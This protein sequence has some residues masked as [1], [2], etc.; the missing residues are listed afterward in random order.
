MPQLVWAYESHTDLV[1]R[2]LGIDP[3]EFRRRNL[4][5]DG[6]AQATGTIMHDAAISAVLDR[7]AVRMGWDQPFDRGTE[8]LKRGRGIAIGFKASISPTTSVATVAIA[9][10]GS[11]TLYCGTVDM[12]QGSTTA[13]AQIAARH[14]GSGPKRCRSSPRPRSCALTTAGPWLALEWPFPAETR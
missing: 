5:R 13:M 4:L 11:C 8:T 3:V 7:L 10:D 14:Q 2:A 1:A 6:V 12:G 9:A